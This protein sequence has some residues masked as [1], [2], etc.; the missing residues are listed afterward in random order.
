[1]SALELALVLIAV[2]AVCGA[3]FALAFVSRGVGKIDPAARD[4]PLGF[5]LLILPGSL[6]L[7]PLLAWKWAHV[8]RSGAT[9]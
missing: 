8:N 1:M 7:W 3:L 5:R 9:P 2:Y 6:A 4:A